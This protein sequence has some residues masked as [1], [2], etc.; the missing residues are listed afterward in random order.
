MLFRRRKRQEELARRE[1]AGE[2]LWT[3]NFDDRI[4]VRLVHLL[5]TTTNE[6]YPLSEG[7]RLRAARA[8]ILEEEGLFFLEKPGASPSDQLEDVVFAVLRGDTDMVATIIEAV[9]RAL[10]DP[11]LNRFRTREAAEF[12]T[13]VR[14][15]LAE[16]RVAFDFVDGQMVPFESRE[17]HVA[18]VEPA[19]KLLGG[20]RGWD[21][22]ERAY[23]KA[24]EEIGTDPS[25]AITDAATAL[26]E[27]LVHLGCEGHSLGPLGNDA[28]HRQ[29]IRQHDR[30]LVDWVS[31]DRSTSGDAHN[32]KPATRDD[33]WF[34]VH[35]VG[36]LILRL[37][38][39]APRPS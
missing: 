2:D 4:R 33:A 13:T 9:Y 17:M 19:L 16:H 25:D 36:A 23:R 35:I 29:I 39:D 22:V 28:A 27:A 11:R 12:G 21:Q 34:A 31:A 15:L 14:K 30:K 37:A 26:Q 5:R 20:R 8:A 24:L 6:E 18:V 1:V 32:A 7:D 10:T 3:S 38:G